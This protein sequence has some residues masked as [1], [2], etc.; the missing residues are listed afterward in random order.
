MLEERE[1]L[2]ERGLGDLQD[3]EKR[4]SAREGSL[5]AKLNRC[6]LRHLSRSCCLLGESYDRLASRKS[7]SPVRVRN[8]VHHPIMYAVPLTFTDHDGFEDICEA[9]R[10]VT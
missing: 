2:I 1:A 4:L 8:I 5:E 10:S 6:F 9:T 3:R 7:V